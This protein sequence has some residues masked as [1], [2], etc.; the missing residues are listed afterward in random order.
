MF[1]IFKKL[2]PKKDIS[3]QFYDIK[4]V[5]NDDDDYDD[6]EDEIKEANIN[7]VKDDNVVLFVKNLFTFLKKYKMCFLS[8]TIIFQDNNNELFNFLTFD[9]IKNDNCNGKVE[10]TSPHYSYTHKKV[11]KKNDVESAETCVEK[12]LD[13]LNKKLEKYSCSNKTTL[14][15]V[16]KWNIF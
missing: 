12:F 9:N 1:N 11:Y 3:T 16:L 14:M 15:L 7:I 8:G 13:P 5:D 10:A 6:D 4:D 2:Y